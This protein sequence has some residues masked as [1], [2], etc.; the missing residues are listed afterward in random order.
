MKSARNSWVVPVGL[1]GAGLILTACETSS[2]YSDGDA[3]VAGPQP[4]FPVRQQ[5]TTGGYTADTQV[6]PPEQQPPQSTPPSQAAIPGSGGQ[7]QSQALPPLASATPE[8]AVPAPP[9]SPPEPVYRTTTDGPV[10]DAEGNGEV[11]VIAQGDTLYSIAREM[12]VS[13]DYLAER[14][15]ISDPSRIRI[16]QRIEGPGSAGKAYVVQSGDTLSAIARRFNVSVADLATE[17]NVSA[18]GV[19]RPNQRLLL[20][21]GYRDSGP[22][23]IQ[24]ATRPAAP[25]TPTPTPVRPATPAAPTP[26]TPVAPVTPPPAV[27]QT[28]GPATVSDLQTAG[29]GMFRWPVQGPVTGGYGSRGVNQQSN[30]IT[31]SAAYGDNVAASAAGQ[32]VYAGDELADF[33]NLVLIQHGDTGFVTAY[34]HLADI[35]VTPQQNVTQGQII[36]RVGQSGGVTGP[37]LYFEMRHQP[38]TRDM[39]RPFDPMLL[40]PPR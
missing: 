38:S 26:V 12:G 8:P 9:P 11:H 33:G 13:V 18:S 25:V 4:N 31:I 5:P 2:P 3:R 17:N 14:N 36:G 35:S 29:R 40:L 21:P 34:A 16:G 15:G 10:V 19:I 27:P 7:V 28:S 37:Q 22:Q 32:V 24:V 1:I 39:A 23:R 20:P 6:L 30:G